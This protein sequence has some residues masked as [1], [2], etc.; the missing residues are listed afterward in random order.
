MSKKKKEKDV[1]QKA[2]DEYANPQEGMPVDEVRFM[3]ETLFDV[4]SMGFAET[5]KANY[6][7]LMKLN[8]AECLQNVFINASIGLLQVG[9]GEAD[10]AVKSLNY[11]G[12]SLVTAFIILIKDVEK[13]E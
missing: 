7:Q 6:E 11:A 1:V 9:R 3:D 13:Q 12:A 4:V 10:T 8:F 5:F 2:V